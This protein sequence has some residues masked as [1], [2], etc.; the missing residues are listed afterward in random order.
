MS[1]MSQITFTTLGPPGTNH[2]FVTRKYLDF[3]GLSPTFATRGSE[4]SKCLIYRVWCAQGR[5]HNRTRQNDYGISLASTLGG[6][7]SGKAIFKRWSR[8]A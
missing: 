8:M 3:H 6:G 2:E 7:W 1:A 5:H 4:S